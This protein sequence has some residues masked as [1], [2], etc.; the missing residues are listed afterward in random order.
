MSGSVIFQNAP[1]PGAAEILRGLLHRRIDVGER[2]D[3]VEV[4]DRVERKRLD[5]G[6]APELVRREPVERPAVR[7][8][9]ELDDEGVERAVLPE[10]LLDADGADERRQDHR[11]ENE[12]AEQPLAAEKRTGR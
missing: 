12:R 11:D 10:D 5:D 1:Q 3:G 4:D 2:G 9:A 7:P 6:D 8:Q